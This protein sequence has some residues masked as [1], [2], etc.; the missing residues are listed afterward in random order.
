MNGKRRALQRLN[1]LRS[2]SPAPISGRDGLLIE[3][4][5]FYDEPVR[6]T[7][8]VNALCDELDGRVARG[9]G[10]AP[11][12][13]PRILVSG[14]PMAL[15]N[16]KLHNVVENAGAIVVNDESCI[17][18]RYFKDLMDEGDATLDGMLEKLTDRY[19]KIDCSCFTP[20]DER[21]VQVVKEAREVERAGG[22]P[23]Q[24]PVLPHLQHRGDQGPRGLREGWHPLHR[25]RV[26][27]LAGGHRSDPDAGGG[28]PGADPSPRLM[29][30]GI[31]LGSRTIKVAAVED[32]KLVDS[33]IAESG[34]EPH[35]QALA[36]VKPYHPE[37]IVATGYGRHLAQRHFAQET[38]TEIRAHALGARY[39]F[40]EARAVLDVGG[41]D[42]K[43]I[44]LDEAGRVA[45]F[46][47]NDRCA[48]GT[49]RFLEIMACL[50]RLHARRVRSG[51]AR[52]DRRGEDQQ[53]V[54]GLRRVRGDFS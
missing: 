41:Q 18:T 2:H 35:L 9:E 25:D 46:Q 28:L 30:V 26:R 7:E 3:Q 54:H 12:A 39:F 5:A 38:I 45:N 4:V 43:V 24:S 1:R 31:D 42:S 49:G 44:A 8:K 27:L 34:Y 48:A 37:R 32:G 40:P 17:G 52:R 53:H 16:W 19:M 13:A 15:P 23:L 50:A 51:R 36:M 20:N 14:T 29:I 33:R 47:M 10:V 21:P 11:A 6:F 22:H